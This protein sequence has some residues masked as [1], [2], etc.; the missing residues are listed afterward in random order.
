MRG[1]CEC[2]GYV[3]GWAANQ[4]KRRRPTH[5]VSSDM[6][7]NVVLIAASPTAAHDPP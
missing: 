5:G 3:S 1:A 6:T 2:V 7:P 4:L